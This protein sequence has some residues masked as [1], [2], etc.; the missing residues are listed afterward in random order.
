M[1]RYWEK[2][3]E[4][5][6]VQIKPENIEDLKRFTSQDVAFADNCC[7]LT[8]DG[9]LT[10]RPIGF[11]IVRADPWGDTVMLNPTA[12]QD[13]YEPMIDPSTISTKAPLQMR[14]E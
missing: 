11:W 14:G 1:A 5:E 7:F 8:I 10:K 3:P 9:V 13:K 6:A 4:F 2:R 12:F